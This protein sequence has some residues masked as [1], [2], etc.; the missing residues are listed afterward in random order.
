MRTGGKEAWILAVLLALFV[1]ATAFLT[2]RG[3]LNQRRDQPTTYSTGR[4]GTKALLELMGKQGFAAKRFERPY[5]KLPAPPGLLIMFEP[6]ARE[7]GNLGEGENDALW[8]WVEKGGHFVLVVSKKGIGRGVQLDAVGVD[9]QANHAADLPVDSGSSPLLRD[10][11]T[12]HVEG[13]IR[14]ENLDKKSQKTLV[15]DADGAY[16]LTF[17]RGK[18]RATVVTEGLA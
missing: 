3:E 1:V 13:D 8:K 15:S 17:T 14:L 10:V 2:Q 9:V 11:H 12:L 7:G 5:T 16:A 18:G 4:G 6:I